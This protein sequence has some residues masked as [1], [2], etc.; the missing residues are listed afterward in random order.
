MGLYKIEWKKSAIN[1]LKSLPKQ[2]IKRVIKKVKEL[3]KNPTPKGVKKLLGCE[4]FYRLRVGKYRIVYEIKKG[5][6]IIFIIKVGHRK[7]VYKNK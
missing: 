6:L 5:K 4:R 7:N 2:V 1:E 3:E